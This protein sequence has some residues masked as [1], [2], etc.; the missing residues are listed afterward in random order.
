MLFTK[1][2]QYNIQMFDKKKVIEL[3][4]GLMCNIQSKQL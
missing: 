4:D 3:E 1:T 2:K